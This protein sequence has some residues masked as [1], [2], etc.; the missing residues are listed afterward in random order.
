MDGRLVQI[1]MLGSPKAEFVLAPILRKRLWITGSMLRPR[2]PAEKG[3]IRD[4]LRAKVWP[5][6]ESG[7]I[8][9]VVARTFP[10]DDAAGA[11]RLMESGTFV[12]KIVLEI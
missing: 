12:G 4:E 11:H 6:F 10:L 5:L 8:A 1:G 7:R 2:S 9:P 3:V